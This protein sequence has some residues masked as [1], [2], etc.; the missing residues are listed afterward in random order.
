MLERTFIHIPGIGP[1]TERALWARGLAT[2]DE[3]VASPARAPF[4]AARTQQVLRCVQESQ[5]CLAARDH[6]YFARLL[7]PPEHW[8][9][10]DAFGS[11]VAYVDIETTGMGGWAAITVIGLYDGQR[12]RTYVRGQNLDEFAE[13]VVGYPL[14]VTFNGTTFDLP[15]IRRAFPS[16]QLDQLHVDLRWMLRR[17]GHTGGLKSI[18]RKLRLPERSPRIAGLDGWDAVRLWH[19]H[20]RGSEDSLQL[21]IE[22]NTADIE[23]LELLMRGAYNDL[24][25]R[26]LEPA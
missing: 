12:T 16:L 21:L 11:R 2:W 19:E 1:V 4:S 24:V 13:D 20:V 10:F 17:L 22:Y 26:C 14:L 6:T 7:K 5:S 23:N 9:A 8:R 3:F 15:F 25:R 18:E